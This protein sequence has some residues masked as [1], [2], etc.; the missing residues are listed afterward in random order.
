V[1][2]NQSGFAGA[3]GVFRFRPNGGNDRSLAVL[4]VR[5][6]SAVAVSPAPRALAGGA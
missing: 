5:N 3:D 1:L 4:E 2:T 6:G